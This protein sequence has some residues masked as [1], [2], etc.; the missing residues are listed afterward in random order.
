MWGGSSPSVL[1]T[2]HRRRWRPARRARPPSM[3]REGARPPAPPRGKRFGVPD[4]KPAETSDARCPR[5]TTLDR[6]ARDRVDPHAASRRTFIAHAAPSSDVYAVSAG[7]RYRSRP[8][9]V[10]RV[11]GTG[12]RPSSCSPAS[13]TPATTIRRPK[14]AKHSCP[15]KPPTSS[16]SETSPSASAYRPQQ[17]S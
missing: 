13:P 11:H 15:A 16:P 6:R 12:A 1:S 5:L 7:G 17:S 9:F 14:P 3:S 4:A 8:G 2:R 10:H